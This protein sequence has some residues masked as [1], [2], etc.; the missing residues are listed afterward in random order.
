MPNDGG[1][2]APS[3]P[4]MPGPIAGRYR[5]TGRL[6]RG[7]MGTVWRA[8][9]ELLDRQVAVKE[10][11]FNEDLSEAEQQL[12][13][14]RALREARSVAQ[15][16]HPH[17]VVLHDVVEQ[18]GRPWIVMELIDGRSLSDVLAKDGPVEPRE[19]ARIGAAVA[20]ALHAAH[21][22]GV[23]HRDIKPANVLIE[24]ETGRVVLTDFG[25]ARVSGTTTLTETGVFVGSP[26]YT[27]PE[28]MSGA[29]AG[30]E[31]D[32][33]S[34]GVLLC[35]SVDGHSPFRRDSIGGVLHAVVYDEIRPP[36]SA[37]PL[38]PVVSA[39]LERDTGRRM[40]APA[41][42]LWLRTYAE[43]GEATDTGHV[44]TITQDTVVPPDPVLEPAQDP[45]PPLT[46]SPFP[47][48]SPASSEGR[49]SRRGLLAGA[50]LALV[51]GGGAA[52]AVLTMN[53]ADGSADTATKP[54]SQP[55]SATHTTPS[56]TPSPTPTPVPAGF[57]TV[58][59]VS[60]FSVVLPTGY[61]RSVDP[62]RI[63]YYSPGKEF[64]FGVRDEKPDPNGPMAVMTAQHRGGPAAYKGYRDGFVTETTKDGGPAALWEFTW[65]GYPGGG[66][67]RTF[68]LC[69]TENGRQYDMWVS[70][71]VEKS[72]QG[73]QTFDTARN[74]FTPR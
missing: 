20:G 65:D 35:A 55:P 2:T 4:R 70:S 64:R 54:S 72:E 15:I 63:Y 59:D 45:T 69:W 73:R 57:R 43:T 36:A 27:S 16:R 38:L 61:D 11:H 60:G 68:D 56:V 48:A 37:G 46:P 6:G 1:H 14:D 8:T 29:V 50:L 7:G 28:R 25:I 22:R 24:R 17:V 34:V 49:K 13:R 31:S 9:D 47:V 51:V 5:I 19:A 53:G 33:W 32:L 62:P 23:L 42:E 30:P 21:E 10:L 41:A 74:S 44:P 39:L 52:A 26:E 40:G 71:P 58:T 18:D 3:A 12:Y 66:A 67:R